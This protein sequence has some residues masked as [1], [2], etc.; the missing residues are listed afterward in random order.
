MRRSTAL[1]S[2]AAVAIMASN[3]FAQG[4]ANFAGT[5]NIVQDPNAAAA[6]P[7][8][9]MGRGGRGGGG[10]FG[11][12]FTATQD[13]KTLTITRT[14]QNGEVK[15]VYNLDGSDSKNMVQGRG[16]ATEQVSH[17]KWDGANLV[18]TRS[19]DMGGTAIEIKQ[20]F[21]VDKDG[22]LWIETT[23]PGQDG[24]PVSTKVQYKKA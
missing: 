21:S 3:A 14:T 18:I 13:D 17:A 22:N 12:T 2:V 19:Q 9:G 11:P 8:G 15:T 23:R 6:A 4:K 1:M 24:N 10:G 16:G 7:G 5:W 20:T